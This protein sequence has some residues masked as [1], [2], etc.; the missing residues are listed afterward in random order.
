VATITLKGLPDDLYERIRKRAAEH[1][2]SINSEIIFCLE[3]M[4]QSRRVD[5]HSFLSQ[6]D[7]L[8][9]KTRISP[10]TDEI[11]RAAKEEGRP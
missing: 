1:R 2:R 6:V 3:R 8:R 7:R 9:R 4:F 5:P 10:L 11:L